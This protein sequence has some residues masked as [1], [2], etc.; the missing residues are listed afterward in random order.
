MGA[1]DIATSH[2]TYAWVFI[3][4]SRDEKTV[5]EFGVWSVEPT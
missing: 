4:I 1:N 2:M 3:E 5:I